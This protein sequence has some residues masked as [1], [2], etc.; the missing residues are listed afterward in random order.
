MERSGGRGAE[1]EMR[2]K[3]ERQVEGEKESEGHRE[4]GRRRKVRIGR[5]EKWRGECIKEVTV[6]TRQNPLRTKSPK[7]TF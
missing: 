1:R 5:T 7:F 6:V 2:R 4:E 3:I